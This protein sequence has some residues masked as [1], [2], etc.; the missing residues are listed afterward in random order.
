[1]S[2]IYSLKVSRIP[3]VVILWYLD[4]H[5]HVP[6][7]SVPITTDVSSNLDQG[8]VYNIMWLSL[9]VTWGRFVVFS[10]PPIFST[11]KTD[12]HDVTEILLKMPLNTIK[13]AHNQ[14]RYDTI[15]DG[16]NLYFYSEQVCVLCI[17]IIHLIFLNCLK[18]N[19]YYDMCFMVTDVLNKNYYQGCDL[20]M[21]HF[22]IKKN[23][24]CKSI[25]IDL[26]HSLYEFEFV[27]HVHI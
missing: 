4:L 18:I 25:F 12:C 19:I 6:M 20:V 26:S 9:S 15:F 14:N 13:Q 1:M 21:D 27:L 10:G 17:F 11:N 16:D 3:V 7:Q 8:E 24:W 2:Q 23:L 5:L 22:Y